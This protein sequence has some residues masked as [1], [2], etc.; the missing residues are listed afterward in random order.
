MFIIILTDG[1]SSGFQRISKRF[2]TLPTRKD[3]EVFHGSP[4]DQSHNET[5]QTWSVL[6]LINGILVGEITVDEGEE[7]TWGIK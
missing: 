2:T 4:L 5:S 6:D 3:V 1:E 7:H